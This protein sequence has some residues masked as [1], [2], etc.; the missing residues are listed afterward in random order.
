MNQAGGFIAGGILLGGAGAIIGSLTGEK[1][2]NELVSSID[3]KVVVENLKK[4]IIMHNFFTGKVKRNT[5]EYKIN[6]QDTQHWHAKFSTLIHIA[7]N[8]RFEG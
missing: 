8:K 1:Y 5:D 7:K 3:L 6:I 2:A 4:P